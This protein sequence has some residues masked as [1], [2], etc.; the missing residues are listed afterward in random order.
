MYRIF[1]SLSLFAIGLLLV[2]LT[3]GLTGPDYNALSREYRE[4]VQDDSDKAKRSGENSASDNALLNLR[5]RV[6]EAQ[7]HV[8]LHILL[9]I[10][11]A[12]VTVLVQ[13]VGVTYFIGT[14]RW[15]KEVVETYELNPEWVQRANRIKRRSFPW[16][17]L[18]I[19]T[20]LAIASF[21]AAADPGTLSETTAKWVTPH[22]WLGIIGTL[23]IGGCLWF[24]AVSIASNQQVIEGILDAV[25]DVRERRGLAVE[26]N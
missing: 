2:D 9:G 22:Y 25:R 26:A 4:R 3:L 6:N 11:A 24:Q 20:V 14:G 18:G 5:A 23:V 15:C 16:A 7:Q 8:R 10:L 19:G 13:S 12:V 21:G 17:M 1:G